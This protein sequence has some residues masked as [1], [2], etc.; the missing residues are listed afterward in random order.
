M[1]GTLRQEPSA[2]PQPNAGEG[3]AVWGWG[4]GPAPPI[5]E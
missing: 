5:D 3:T 2:V 4:W 1:H